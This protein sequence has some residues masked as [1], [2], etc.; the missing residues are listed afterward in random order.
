MHSKFHDPTGFID[1]F[2]C[3]NLLI[4]SSAICYKNY[5]GEQ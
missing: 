3:L 1:R 5:G 2:H 4:E